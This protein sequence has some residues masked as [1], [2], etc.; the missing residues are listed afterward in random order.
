MVHRVSGLL[1]SLRF[2]ISQFLNT[3][4]YRSNRSLYLRILRAK[5]IK[6]DDEDSKGSPLMTEA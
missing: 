4:Y 5:L 3:K 6:N 1:L 2:I